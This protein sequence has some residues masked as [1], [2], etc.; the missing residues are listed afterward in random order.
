[1]KLNNFSL[2]IITN[3]VGHTKRCD[4]KEVNAKRTVT[5]I[6]PGMV[7]GT[8]KIKVTVTRT[9]TATGT[10]TVTGI[11]TVRRTVTVWEQ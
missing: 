9:V 11:V 10:V 2:I 8:I 3:C 1:M 5:A 6:E 7:T 4:S